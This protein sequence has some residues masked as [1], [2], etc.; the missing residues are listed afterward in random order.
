[1]TRFVMP[2][3]LI[4]ISIAVFFV[5]TNPFYQEV[6]KL[7]GQAG[8]YEE[9]LKNSKALENARDTLTQKYNSIDPVN[10]EKLKKLLPENIDNIRLILEIEQ[11]ALPYGMV[12]RDIK[13]SP[14]DDTKGTADTKAAI[15][16]GGAAALPSSAK[17]Y[18][19][20]D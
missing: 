15:V 2:I 9:A 20:W 8:S 14:T 19:V 7:R 4:G 1:M 6:F 17:D 10:L 12:L 18:G 3:I 11:I 5:F 16:Q 13:Y